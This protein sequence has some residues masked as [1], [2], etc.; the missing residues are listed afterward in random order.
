MKSEYVR[1]SNDEVLNVSFVF[2]IQRIGSEIYI[3]NNFGQNVRVI[4]YPTEQD[5]KDKFE[6]IMQQLFG[7]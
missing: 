4:G 6:D 3:N 5:A 7:R 2:N 1:I